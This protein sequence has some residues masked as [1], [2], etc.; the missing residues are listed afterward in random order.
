MIMEDALNRVFGKDNRSYLMGLAMTWIVLFHIYLWCNMSS[1]STSWWIDIFDKGALGVDVFLLLSAYGLQCSIESKSLGHFYRNR[2]KR[3]FPLYFLF[4]LTLFATFEHLCPF[5][6]MIIQSVCQITGISLFMYADFFSCG[7]CFDWF[8]PAII[9]LYLLFPIISK[10][11]RWIER[12]G[13]YYDFLVLLLLVVAGVWIRENKHFSFGLLAIR[14]PIIYIGILI[15]FYLKCQKYNRLLILCVVA[16][17]LG[18]VS[19][20]EEMRISLLVL[21]LLLTFSLTRFQLPLKKFICFIGRHS[22][23]IYLAHIFPVAFII[24]LHYTENIFL[25]I[26][27][28]ITLTGLIT[29]LFSF[30]HKEFWIVVDK[31]SH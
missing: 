17:C 3:L 24:P 31:C 20:N 12:K 21:P 4:L 1:I 5:E 14:M 11:V 13:S 29:M 22:Y 9:M 23:E 27:I 7:F 15:H 25:L 26:A 8:T 19:G 2:I 28:T 16:A 6:K 10:L 30:I 18:L